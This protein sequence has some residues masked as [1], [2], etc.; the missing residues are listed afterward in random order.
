MEEGRTTASSSSSPRLCVQGAHPLASDVPSVSPGDT[1]HV[2]G[3]FVPP[4]TPQHAFSHPRPLCWE[5]DKL[6]DLP[7]VHGVRIK[8]SCIILAILV[9]DF[10]EFC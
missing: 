8:A 1:V 7:S 4:P 5:R 10:A 6:A 3:G 9:T 2:L